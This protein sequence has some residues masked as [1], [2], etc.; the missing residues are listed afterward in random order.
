[1]LEFIEKTMNCWFSVVDLRC[2]ATI[3][4][5]EYDVRSHISM[6]YREKST[7]MRED[8]QRLLRLYGSATRWV[9]ATIHEILLVFV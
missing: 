1:M 3:G 4:H 9:S 8:K 5:I 7:L 6:G 2:N